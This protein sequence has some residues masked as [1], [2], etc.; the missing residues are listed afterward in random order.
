MEMKMSILCK[1]G[2]SDHDDMIAET[3]NVWDTMKLKLPV[4]LFFYHPAL[5]LCFVGTNEDEF[6]NI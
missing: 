1:S 4:L 3:V 5:S 6:L 2:R